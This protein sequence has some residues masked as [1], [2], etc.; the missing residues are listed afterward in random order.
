MKENRKYC[1]DSD[2]RIGGKRRCIYTHCLREECGHYLGNKRNKKSPQTK[3]RKHFVNVAVV[4]LQH[5]ISDGRGG[6]V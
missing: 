2:C 6:Y 1:L 5:K 3:H 4:V